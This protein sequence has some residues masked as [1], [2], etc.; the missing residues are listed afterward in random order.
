MAQ[1]YTLFTYTVNQE[2][3]RERVLTHSVLAYRNAVERISKVADADSIRA[4][5]C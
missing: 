2:P 4:T 5:T 1:M 3:Q